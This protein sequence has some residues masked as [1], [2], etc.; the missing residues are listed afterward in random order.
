VDTVHQGHYDGKPGLYHVN[1]VD[2]VTPWQIVGCVETIAERHFA[3]LSDPP[4]ALCQ[5]PGICPEFLNHTVAKLLYKLLV[6][7]TKSRAYRTTDNA[8]VEG[9]TEQ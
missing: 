6:E 8:L 3:A 2:T 4:V 1:A 9:R 5:L 7:F